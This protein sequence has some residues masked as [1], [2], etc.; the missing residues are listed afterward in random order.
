MEI[1]QN[2]GVNH[3]RLIETVVRFLNSIWKKWL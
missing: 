3:N 2:L 1:V